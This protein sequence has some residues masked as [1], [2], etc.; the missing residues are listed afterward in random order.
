MV[1][2]PAPVVRENRE[3]VRGALHASE[4]AHALI[5]PVANGSQVALRGDTPHRRRARLAAN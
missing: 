5:V 2:V 1:G 3:R 4:D